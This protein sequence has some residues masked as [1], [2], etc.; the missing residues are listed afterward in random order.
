[1]SNFS[2]LPLGQNRGD[3]LLINADFSR[4]ALGQVSETTDQLGLTRLAVFLKSYGKKPV[5]LDISGRVAGTNRA[6]EL[7]DFLVD[8]VNNFHIFGFHLTSWNI[9]FTIKAVEK[10]PRGTPLIF[11]GPLATADPKEVLKY[12]QE[13]GFTKISAVAGYGENLT[14]AILENENWNEIEGLWTPIQTGFLQ[15]P[16]SEEINQWPLLDLKFSPF[17]QKV[18]L[19]CVKKNSLGDFAL[20]TVFSAFGLDVNHGCPYDCSYC[21]LPAFGRKVATYTP[22]KVVKEMQMIGEEAGIFMFTFTNSN[23]LFW[24]RQWIL[25]FCAEL[26]KKYVHEWATWTGYHHPLTINLLSI[27]DFK[28]LKYCGCE[29]IV[30]GVQSIDP[31]VLDFFKRPRNTFEILQEIREKTKAANV[32]LVID[33]ITGIPGEDLRLIVDFFQ[34]CEENDVLCR[35]FL[36]KIYPGTAIAKLTPQIF[37][38]TAEDADIDQWKNTHELVPIIGDLAPTLESYAVIPKQKLPAWFVKAQEKLRKNNRK[39]EAQR[40][41]RLGKYFI[42]NENDASNLLT[43]AIPQ[44]IKI[45]ELVKKAMQ[46]MLN[47]MLNPSMNKSNECSQPSPKSMLQ[48]IILADENA[49]PMVKK[50]QERMRAELGEEKFLALRRKYQ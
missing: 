35:E 40:K 30:V 39:L 16:T 45:P 48:T 36:L 13:K 5:I 47:S 25:D 11:G 49:P 6:E 4:N 31:K 33:Y 19:P 44:N 37:G 24:D 38:G 12:F 27:A 7:A 32:E 26:E 22:E 43:V 20:S 2:F 23:L 14:L 15:R 42:T 8:L 50:M 21:S 46:L 3:I 28:R 41:V 17:A 29:Q 10:L 34:W 1:L 18:F 9:S